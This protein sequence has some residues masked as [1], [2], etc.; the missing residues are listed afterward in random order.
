MLLT[1][2][3][4]TFRVHIDVI[5]GLAACSIKLQGFLDAFSYGVTPSVLSTWRARFCPTQAAGPAS[6]NNNYRYDEEDDDSTGDFVET[7][8]HGYQ[9]ETELFSR[10]SC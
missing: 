3:L 9:R 8:M 2:V 1:R 6:E 4:D 7:P 10:T 5:T